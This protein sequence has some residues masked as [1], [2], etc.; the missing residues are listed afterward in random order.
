MEYRYILLFLPSINTFN[1]AR[2]L[3][4][5]QRLL[6]NENITIPPKK[7]QSGIFGKVAFV[8]VKKTRE[9]STTDRHTHKKAHAQESH[10]NIGSVDAPADL[11]V[12]AAEIRISALRL[13][14]TVRRDGVVMAHARR[15]DTRGSAVLHHA[16]VH[17][18]VA[19][20]F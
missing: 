10:K 5:M 16:R 4:T 17:V 12:D 11:R 20:W 1:G 13:A 14:W 2:T 7:Q 3:L 8:R 18:I 19:Y 6:G 15:R 9:F